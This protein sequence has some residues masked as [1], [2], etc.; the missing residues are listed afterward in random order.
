MKGYVGTPLQEAARA[1]LPQAL[2]GV[3]LGVGGGVA[4]WG[5]ASHADM[6]AGGC[7]GH[8]RLYC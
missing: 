1:R 4:I 6:A 7:S 8:C 2:G 5:L 3:L